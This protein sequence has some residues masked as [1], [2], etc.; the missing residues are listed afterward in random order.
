M[1]KKGFTLAEML[2][3]ITILAILG[4]LIFPAVEKSLKD[5]KE[6]L[7]RVQISNI[8]QGAIAWVSEN[9]FS[10]PEQ[11]GETMLL[12]LYQLKQSG[13]ISNDIT[14]PT[15]KNLFP[16]DMIIK[17]TRTSNDYVA[18]VQEDTG[19]PKNEKKYNPLTP[20]VRLNGS[21]LVYLEYVKN[22]TQVY[23]DPGV[24]ALSSNGTPVTNI[25]TAT[26]DSLDNVVLNI[27][28]GRMGIYNVYYDVTSDDITV[29]VIRTVI[30]K[31]SK[32]PV[33]T[34]PPVTTVSRSNAA[35]YNLK[36]TVTVVDESDYI[37][38]VDRTNLPSVAGT[39]TITYTATD[40]YGNTS[41]KR[42]TIIVE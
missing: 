23:T 28:Y 41:T 37:L 31:D 17:I 19:E 27:S 21:E 15:T 25:T 18:Q 10:A 12:T 6:D 40:T 32:A 35:S 7:Y 29:R 24:T 22:S 30:V 5:G 4:L 3:V 1:K 36:T 11:S 20:D 42:R 34:V 39:Y 33:I 14:D 13:K 8:E 2:G 38:S 16:D 9:V 26:K